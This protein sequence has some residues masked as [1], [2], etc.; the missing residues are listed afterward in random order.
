MSDLEKILKGTKGVHR[1]YA[2]ALHSVNKGQS[3]FV[4]KGKVFRPIL[5][6]SQVLVPSSVSNQS[7]IGNSVIEIEA[8]NSDD[9]I[10]DEGTIDSNTSKASLEE[11]SGVFSEQE[12]EVAPYL[13]KAILTEGDIRSVITIL[14]KN[15]EYLST[16]QSYQESN[17]SFQNLPSGSSS[18]HQEENYPTFILPNHLAE[19]RKPDINQ[20]LQEPILDC[21]ASKQSEEPFHCLK[22][23]ENPLFPEVKTQIFHID[24]S[25]VQV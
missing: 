21:I 13:K 25:Q 14:H 20:I 3:K 9:R 16:I 4:P 2:T 5:K 1:P 11:E 8:D 6:S 17:Y 22:I 18:S 10:E 7:S 24:P 23:F 15:P 12:L 19:Q